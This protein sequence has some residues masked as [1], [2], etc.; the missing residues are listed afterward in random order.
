MSRIRIISDLERTAR[1]ILSVTPEKLLDVVPID[2]QAAIIAEV[3][4]DWLSS[5]QPSEVDLHV[6]YLRFQLYFTRPSDLLPLI[7][8]FSAHSSRRPAAFI[9][10]QRDTVGWRP[11]RVVNAIPNSKL[12]ADPNLNLFQ[13]CSLSKPDVRTVEQSRGNT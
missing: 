2:G 9:P 11:I 12:P 1:N 13:D 8:V 10:A 5:T 6:Y 3:S 7:V 4:A